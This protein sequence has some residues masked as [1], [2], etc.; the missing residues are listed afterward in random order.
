MTIIMEGETGF[1]DLRMLRSFRVLR[2]LKLISRVPSEF[3]SCKFIHAANFMQCNP[4]LPF[5]VL[6]PLPITV[7]LSK[8]FPHPLEND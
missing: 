5:T 8:S 1:V 7:S 2:P 3:P 4:I 6:G